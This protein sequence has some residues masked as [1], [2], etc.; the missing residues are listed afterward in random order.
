MHTEKKDT[1]NYE[2]YELSTDTSDVL[3]LELK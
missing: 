1:N 3:F 2:I